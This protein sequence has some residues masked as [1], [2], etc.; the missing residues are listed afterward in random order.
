MKSLLRT[1]LVTGVLVVAVA[2]VAAWP[3]QGP[4][5]ADA[6]GWSVVA[7]V[8]PTALAQQPRESP[9]NIVRTPQR[10]QRMGGWVGWVLL[11]GIPAV[12]VAWVVA[13]RRR[14]RRRGDGK[15]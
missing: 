9:P 2:A 6:A 12:I 3:G 1:L 7:H 4:V 15:E 5:R 11:L 8:V 10:S 14:M 13:R